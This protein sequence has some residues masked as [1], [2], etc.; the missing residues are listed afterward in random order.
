[1]TY[2]PC[3][4]VIHPFLIVAGSLVLVCFTLDF[5]LIGAAPIWGVRLWKL[6]CAIMQHESSSAEVELHC[7][8]EA[9]VGLIE[10]GCN[11]VAA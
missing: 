1:M 8:G 4:D 11:C 9:V 7:Q 2:D 6:A 10:E 5:C 3:E